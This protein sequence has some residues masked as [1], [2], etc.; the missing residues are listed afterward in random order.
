MI[1]YYLMSCE[2]NYLYIH[3][4]N[5]KMGQR[6]AYGIWTSYLASNQTAA[7]KCLKVP[8]GLLT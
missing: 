5:R 6:E 8:K 1:N 2:Q 4:K 3:E 7:E